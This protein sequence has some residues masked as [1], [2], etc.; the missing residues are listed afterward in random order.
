MKKLEKILKFLLAIIVQIY[1]IN[2]IKI[3]YYSN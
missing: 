3:Y 2:L 1:F